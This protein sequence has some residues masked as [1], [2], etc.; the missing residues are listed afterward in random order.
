MNNKYQNYKCSKCKTKFFLVNLSQHCPNE[1]N[2][3]LVPLEPKEKNIVSL[4]RSIEIELSL[5]KHYLKDLEDN[6]K[7]LKKRNIK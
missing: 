7:E 4:I 3:L 5:S 6:L 1:C 2:K